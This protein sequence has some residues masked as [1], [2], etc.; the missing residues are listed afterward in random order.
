MKNQYFA[1]ERD[2]FKYDL[3]LELMQAILGFDPPIAADPPGNEAAS[4]EL[5]TAQIERGVRSA[6][7]SATA[8]LR[9]PP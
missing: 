3:L 5:L 1:D 4:V 8:A 7:D 9:R 2:L 6:S